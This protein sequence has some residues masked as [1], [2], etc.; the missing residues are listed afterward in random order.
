MSYYFGSGN[1]A[2]GAREYDSLT[3]IG[4]PSYYPSDLETTVAPV[5]LPVD[6]ELVKQFIADS[7]LA[8]DNLLELIIGSVTEQIEQYLGRDLLT[9]TR[10]AV[11]F[12]AARRV[13]LMP[14]PVASITS[15]K[16]LDDEGTP[17]TL[18]ANSDYY[19]QGLKDNIQ[20]FGLDLKGNTQLEVVFV[21]GYGSASAI[22]SAIRQAIVQESARQFKRRQDPG[23][24][25]FNM[26]NSLTPETYALLQSYI[27]RR[28]V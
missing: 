25:S 1:S 15:V 13:Y 4:V 3:G 27:V 6:L 23:I 16:S 5:G 28:P 12:M 21:T 18:S 10:K 8:S 19:V 22:P 20:L 2:Y 14:V 9:R 11:Y 17:T 24:E 26:V 7:G